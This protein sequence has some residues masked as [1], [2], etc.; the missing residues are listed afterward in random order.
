[1]HVDAGV[2]SSGGSG[3]DCVDFEDDENNEE[4]GL[5]QSKANPN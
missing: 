3:S 1:M 5:A 2:E 4:I